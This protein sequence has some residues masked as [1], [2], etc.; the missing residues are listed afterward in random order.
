MACLEP[1]VPEDYL[2]GGLKP[3][4]ADE[5]DP[6]AED[7]ARRLQPVEWEPD[8]SGVGECCRDHGTR[9][10]TSA[11]KLSRQ[12]T[13]PMF[14]A[15][16]GGVGLWNDGETDGEGFGCDDVPGVERGAPGHLAA[17]RAACA[18]VDPLHLAAWAAS[19]ELSREPTREAPI[20]FQ[21]VAGESCDGEVASEVIRRANFML[22]TL[23]QGVVG[24]AGGGACFE[25][26]PGDPLSTSAQKRGA[27]DEHDDLVSSQVRRLEF[28]AAI[29]RSK[30]QRMHGA[31]QSPRALAAKGTSLRTIKK[32]MG[33]ARQGRPVLT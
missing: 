11:G 28:E 1:F 9:T 32:G 7:L 8:A 6:F 15:F 19:N 2:G 16:P 20:G 10:N 31:N 27:L 33:K 23:M 21:A 24:P 4:A 13:Q 5:V 14:A 29:L 25:T 26:R 22:H 3:V 12:S 30:I 18:G 17:P